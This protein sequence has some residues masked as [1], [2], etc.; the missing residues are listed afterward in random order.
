MPV[1]E[2]GIPSEHVVGED[3]DLAL[4]EG[5]HLRAQKVE[6][7]V[8]VHSPVRI[9]KV[10][11]AVHILGKHARAGNVRPQELV[12]EFV[13]IKALAQLEHM[14]RRVV[15]DVHLSPRT[16]WPGRDAR[17]D[18]V[19]RA[20]PACLPVGPGSQGAFAPR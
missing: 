6:R 9:W 17:V 18:P 2:L 7:E 16:G 8:G 19:F 10:G 12:P 14:P 5:G 1:G 4:P 11:V 20:M 3:L 13:C 15:F